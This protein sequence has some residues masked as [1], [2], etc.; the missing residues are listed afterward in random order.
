MKIDGSNAMTR[1]L[2]MGNQK[3]KRLG[4][5]LS[6]ENDAA[7][8]MEFFNREMNNS[9]TNFYNQLTTNYKKYVDESHLPPSG[10]Q[11]D[12]FRYLVEDID[13]SSNENNIVVSSI[14]RYGASPHQVNKNTYLFTVLKDQGSISF[15]TFVVEFFPPEMTNVRVSLHLQPLYRS[16]VKQRKRLL[17]TV[18]LRAIRKPSSSFTDEA[19]HHHNTFTMTCTGKLQHRLQEEWL[20]MVFTAMF[21]A[22]TRKSMTQSML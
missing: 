13:E 5:P 8:N 17:Q 18:Q 9:N 7:V 10:Q 6:S 21:Q 19:A 4:A 2:N 11:T 15:Y 14:G 22:W 1:E 20:S 16:T 3:I 12:P